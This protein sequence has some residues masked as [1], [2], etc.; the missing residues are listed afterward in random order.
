MAG[1]SLQQ[2][3]DEVVAI[4]S[5]LKRLT[6]Y[7]AELVAKLKAAQEQAGMLGPEEVQALDEVHRVTAAISDAVNAIPTPVSDPEPTP[8]PL[9]EPEP[10]P[11]EPVPP[12]V[13]GNN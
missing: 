10:P 8:E 11:A 3:K 4:F 6:D 5:N 2:F 13:D 1:V 12:T 7:Q 9:P